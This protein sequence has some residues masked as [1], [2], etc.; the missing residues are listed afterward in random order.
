VVRT[1]LALPQTPQVVVITGRNEAL[2]A[3]LRAFASPLLAVRG[4]IDNMA[5]YLAACDLV[6]GKAGPASVM[7]ALAVGR[8]LLVTGYAGL[9]EVKLLRFLVTRGLGHEVR[10]LA[11][12]FALVGGYQASPHR[13]AAVADGC[14]QLDLA[15]MT[16][17]LASYLQQAAT[18][19]FPAERSRQG[20]LV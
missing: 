3:E 8:P 19:G 7:E 2:A 17:R 10:D 18:H 1:L 16:A 11:G 15:G 20:G 6:I 4:F 5:D 12:L 14:R 13:L 9:N